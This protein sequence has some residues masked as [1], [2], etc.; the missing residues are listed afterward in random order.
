MNN[1]QFKNVFNKYRT[2]WNYRMISNIKIYITLLILFYCIG[3]SFERSF[4]QFD[5]VSNYFHTQIVFLVLAP[6]TFSFTKFKPHEEYFDSIFKISY[7]RRYF[8]WII[9][10]WEILILSLSFWLS[11][12][13][14]ISIWNNLYFLCLILIILIL[15]INLLIL[16]NFIKFIKIWLSLFIIAIS[17]GMF[18]LD[19]KF[20]IKIHG[21]V[22]AVLFLITI[23]TTTIVLKRKCYYKEQISKVKQ[24]KQSLNIFKDAIILNYLRITKI[25]ILFNI[26]FI[27][28]LIGGIVVWTFNLNNYTL[29]LSVYGIV[30]ALLASIILIYFIQFKDKISL[31]YYQQYCMNYKW[32]KLILNEILLFGVVIGQ[33]LQNFQLLMRFDKPIDTLVNIISPLIFANIFY[34]IAPIIKKIFKKKS[35]ISF[36]LTFIIAQILVIVSIANIVNYKSLLIAIIILVMIKI[37]NLFVIIRMK[38]N[39][40]S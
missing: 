12:V 24:R 11:S 31:E 28:S 17:I 13:T 14:Y 30:S 5:E 18:Y 27:L 20:H 23:I 1:I 25:T 2:N 10:R 38:K 34:I 32:K 7:K 39:G 6:L 16:F 22:V 33:W 29:F 19:I 9:K 37:I 21:Y 35:I 36:L 3:A 40:H 8:I 15:S 4:W 26:Y